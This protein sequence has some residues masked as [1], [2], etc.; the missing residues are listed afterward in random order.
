M[1]SSIAVFIVVLA[2][3]SRSSGQ[4]DASVLAR[5]FDSLGKSQIQN[6]IFIADHANPR[7]VVLYTDGAKESL[8][9]ISLANGIAR[10]EWHLSRLPDFMS[11]V[12]PANLEVKRT[13]S[14]PVILL[15]GC[16]PHLCGGRGLSGALAYVANENRMYTAS[17]NWE[18]STATTKFD[19]SAQEPTSNNMITR[20][21]LEKMLQDEGY[22]P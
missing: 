9:V 11:V 18:A 17:A 22:N 21:L 19:Y 12:D 15:H 2:L 7:V 10:T 3:A 5:A 1:K 4:T 16:A 13:D 8:S 20:K 6:A 14:G